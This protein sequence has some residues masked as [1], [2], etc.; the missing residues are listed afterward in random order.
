MMYN[1]RGQTIL[2]A[3]QEDN[4]NYKRQVGDFI[5]EHVEN[6]CGGEKAPKIT[7]MLIDLPIDEIREYI[8][9]FDKLKEKVAE[10]SMLLERN[11]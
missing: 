11:G 10:A 7:G 4:P 9:N 6:E 5:Y 8:V 3:C 2:P 1:Q